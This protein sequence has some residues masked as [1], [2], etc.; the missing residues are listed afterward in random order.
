MIGNGKL[1]E[2]EKKIF[3]FLKYDFCNGCMLFSSVCVPRLNSTM[4]SMFDLTGKTALCTGGTR[5]LYVLN[6]TAQTKN[7]T[8]LV[9][10]NFELLMT[11]IEELQ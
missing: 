7:P 6:L 5:G 9:S 10:D 11:L 8:R 4:S 2:G 3:D 1:D